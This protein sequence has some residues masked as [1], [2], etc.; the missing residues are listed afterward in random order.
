MTRPMT[1]REN[2]R[3]GRPSKRSTERPGGDTPARLLDSALSVF[4]KHPKGGY[5]VHAVVAESGISLGSL[6]H[7]FGS[8]DGLSAAL[9]SRCMA[10]LLDAIVA[11]L[12]GVSSPRAAIVA[13]VRSY[14]AFTEHERVAAMFIHSAPSE[15]F[16]A[17][18]AASIA[19]AKAPRLERILA[20]L[21]PHVRSGAIVA[22]PEPLLE[23]LIIGP[24]AEISRRWLAGAPGID[25]EEAARLVP[26]RVWRAVRAS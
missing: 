20:A 16:L 22:L 21:R 10:Q 7:H 11:G 15:R 25:I 26:E 8:M 12:E 18:H 17:E 2:R 6:Y 23:M 13:V 19:A 1:P 3:G 5:S 9:Y 24:V 14:L 4:A